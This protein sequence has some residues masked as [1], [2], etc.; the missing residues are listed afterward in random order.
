MP[1]EINETQIDE[2]ISDALRVRGA[3]EPRAGLEERII[4]GMQAHTVAL[5]RQDWLWVW[6]A[7]AAVAVAVV[8][9]ALSG[10]NSIP[11]RAPVQSAAY[12]EPKASSHS[13]PKANSAKRNSISAHGLRHLLK[14]SEQ[15]AAARLS[16]F[17][18]PAPLSADEESLVAC[19]RAPTATVSGAAPDAQKG[20]SSSPDSLALTAGGNPKFTELA[21]LYPEDHTQSKKQNSESRGT[22]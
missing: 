9:F 4:A 15:L 7:G 3:V 2:L 19:L 13:N 8:F 12:V 18:A 6:T 10:A 22:Q 14:H 11:A 1:E 20:A 21:F 16:V 5:A 17:P